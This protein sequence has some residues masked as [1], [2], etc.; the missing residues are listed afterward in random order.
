[1]RL[2]QT[3]EQL[4]SCCP[5]TLDENDPAASEGRTGVSTRAEP[6]TPAGQEAGSEPDPTA[7]RQH[8]PLRPELG[9]AAYQR[10]A[11][12]CPFKWRC[13][14][15]ALRR[16]NR[17]HR[18]FIPGC[19]RRQVRWVF[20]R[21]PPVGSEASDSQAGEPGLQGPQLFR[22]CGSVE[23]LTVLPPARH[24]LIHQGDESIVVAA[25]EQM[26]QLMQDDVVEAVGRGL[27]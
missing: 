9:E 16:A 2:R 12:E 17:R 21:A 5:N 26:H 20:S 25:F 6:V 4:A 13:E 23:S 19:L 8:E 22:Q 15:I 3:H 14:R 11:P 10:R 7:W 1:M 24:V 27:D 18:N